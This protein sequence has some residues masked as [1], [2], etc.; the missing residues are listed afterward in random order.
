LANVGKS[1]ESSQNVLA[2]VG[3]SGEAHIFLKNNILANAYTRQKCRNFGKYLHS[4]NSH[5]SCRCLIFSPFSSYVLISQVSATSGPDA[6]NHLLEAVRL[7]QS[8]HDNSVCDKMD[9]SSYERKDSSTYYVKDNRTFEKMDTRSFERIDNR[10]FERM[11]SSTNERTD[12]STYEKDNSKCGKTDDTSICEK[13]FSKC[14][15][16]I[17]NKAVIVS[18]LMEI[19]SRVWSWTESYFFPY[20]WFTRSGQCSIAEKAISNL[21]LDD[22]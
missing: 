8:D 7:G 16:V 19:P 10:S 20:Q 2:N 22:Q 3:E 13:T 15:A 17:W 9:S 5:V 21:T 1:G 14:P 18:S 12:N 11:D 4:Q 6:A